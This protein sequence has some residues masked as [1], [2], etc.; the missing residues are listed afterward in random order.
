MNEHGTTFP[1]GPCAHMGTAESIKELVEEDKELPIVGKLSLDRNLSRNDTLSRESEEQQQQHIDVDIVPDSPLS[2]QPNSRA[3]DDGD[4][5]KKNEAND[6]CY[7]PS[8]QQDFPDSQ[9][10]R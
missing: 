5:G 8:S 4:D 9:E 3:L 10:W 6:D 1:P 2:P 7:P